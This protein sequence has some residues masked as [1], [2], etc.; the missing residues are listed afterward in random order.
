MLNNNE[1]T[2][3]IYGKRRQ[4]VKKLQEKGINNQDLLEVFLKLDRSAFV[5]I[6]LG[7]PA[8]LDDLHE[9]KDFKISKELVLPSAYNVAMQMQHANIQK[10]DKVLE[11]GTGSGYL[12]AALSEIGA[13]VLSCEIN[14]ETYS[15]SILLLNYLGYSKIRCVHKDGFNQ[16]NDLG[17]F[18]KIMINCSLNEP[19]KQLFSLLSKDGIM[20]Y[21]ISESLKKNWL[22]IRNEGAAGFKGTMIT[23]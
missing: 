15:R 9:L 16:D 7:R 6:P 4:M 13:E 11:I 12:T 22:V 8:Y 21:P 17:P 2:Y 5:Q 23:I 3:L 18:T 20:I 1:N 19:P 14:K 10:G